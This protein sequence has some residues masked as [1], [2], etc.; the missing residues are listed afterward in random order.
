MKDCKIHSGGR[1]GIVVFTVYN[2]KVIRGNSKYGTVVYTIYGDKVIKGNSKYGKT[3]FTIYNDKIIEG[4]SKFGK[5]LFT[6]SGDSIIEGSS[7]Y[8]SKGYT[9][10]YKDAKTSA[11]R[12]TSSS[13]VSSSYDEESRLKRE[14]ESLE[15][16]R[17][18]IERERAKL[19][20]ERKKL[21]YERWYN[22][23]TPFER[24]AEDRKI[25]EEKRIRE[26]EAEERRI[27]FEKEQKER[28]AQRLLEEEKAKKAKKKKT[29]TILSV[30]GTIVLLVIGINVGIAINNAI[31]KKRQI[32][33]FNNSPTGIFTAYLSNQQGYS[34]GAFTQY[35]DIEGRGR[36][37]V[38]TEYKKNGFVDNYNRTCD[39]RVT[40]VL[41]PKA[42]CHYTEV[43]G[44]LF[45]NLDGSDNDTSFGTI[46]GKYGFTKEGYPNYCAIAKYGTG[47]VLTQYQSVEFSNVEGVPL[48]GHCYY[49]Y[50]NWDKSYNDYI[51]EWREEGWLAC[52]TSYVY[53][54]ELYKEATGTNLYK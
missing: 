17:I 50:T 32:E 20:E 49:N 33:A 53:A 22:S 30:I 29:I 27:Q 23:L 21:E 8:G 28:E 41:L 13:T 9:I 48:Y 11:S 37:Y 1:Y 19:E 47:S 5:V 6:I 14:Q 7:K 36:I 12:I 18:N 16:E 38:Q 34:N 15:K 45:F 40:T 4:D 52:I 42:D 10:E 3:A 44:F 24:E 25:E 26:R 46:Y 2:D 54:N 39:F 51:T 31:E 35:M 43:Q